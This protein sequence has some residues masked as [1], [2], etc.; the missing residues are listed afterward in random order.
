VLDR[1]DELDVERVDLHQLDDRVL[2]IELVSSPGFS[3]TSTT[4]PATGLRIS[5]C[6]RTSSA[7]F[8]SSSAKRPVFLRHAQLLDREPVLGLGLVAARWPR[9]SSSSPAPLR[10][11]TSCA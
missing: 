7:R 6:A 11:P 4:T 10:A 5:R 2:L 9:R 8:T 3:N 1:Q